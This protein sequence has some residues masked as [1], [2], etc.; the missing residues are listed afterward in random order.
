[1]LGALVKA[2]PLV[3][4]DSLSKVVTERFPGAIG[5]KNV[6]AIRRAYEEARGIE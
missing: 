6:A 2:S 5:E 4:L 1:M 3:S